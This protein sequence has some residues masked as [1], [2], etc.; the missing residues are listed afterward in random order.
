[1][2][3][4]MAPIAIMVV[5]AAQDGYPIIA[6]NPAFTHLT[7]YRSEE[8]LGRHY[9]L[10]QGPDTDPA[11][12][13]RM[14][15]A[16]REAHEHTETLLSY[17]HDGTPFWSAVH[18]VPVRDALGGVTHVVGF[19][20]DVTANRW[21]EETSSRLD[22][23]VEA[24]GEAI[25]TT[26]LSGMVTD[27]NQ[28]AEQ[29]YGYAHDEI[30][31]RSVTILAPPGED[32]EIAALLATI[33][34]GGH[35]ERQE[36]V[37]VTKDGRHI[38]VAITIA[39]VRDSSGQIVATVTIAR[40]ITEFRRVQED[41]DRLYGELEAEFQRTAKMQAQ[42][43]PSAAP[44]VEG[45][46]FAG[47]CLPARHVGGDFFDWLAQDGLVRLSLGDVMGKGMPASL[48][49]AT[50]RAA[51]RAVTSLPVSEAVEAVN[52]ALFP[53]LT[54]SN[55][56]ITLF[57]ASLEPSSGEVTYVD[58]GHGLGFIT[59]RDGTVEPLQQRGLPL[60]ILSD[61][62]Y[63]SVTTTLSPGD[64]LVIHS[65]GLPDARPDLQLDATGVANHLTGL[66]DIQARLERL[67]SLATDVETRPDD[68]TLVL[69]SRRATSGSRS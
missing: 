59:R 25:I 16:V 7:G 42:L 57:H 3:F 32:T 4:I 41:R 56:F 60:G 46:D 2:A 48:L 68:L 31:G 63:P 12:I 20:E 40:D 11:A 62:S 15:T 27:W 1:M 33:R 5:D 6:V 49:T 26:T 55:S 35:V 47:V 28:A 34:T 39:P 8:V 17:R 58:A 54:P 29:M 36:T 69:V 18:M 51:L 23:I 19:L 67:V 43:L 14:T 13:S 50:V 24:S 45:Y 21:S 38:N 66:T 64:T 53:D 52:R 65:D 44:D 37:R 9:P 22:A 30:V 10:L 61:A